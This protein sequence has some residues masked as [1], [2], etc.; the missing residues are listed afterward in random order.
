[1]KVLSHILVGLVFPVLLAQANTP[2]IDA[3]GGDS[4]ATRTLS[5]TLGF[6]PEE[7][8]QAGGVNIVVL[9]YSVPS[10]VRWNGDDLK[11]LV[12]GEGGSTPGKVRVYLNI[13]TSS[14]PQ[15]GGYFY[16]QSNG[17]DLSVP[18]SGCL[19]AFPRV[20]YWDGDGRKDLLIGKSDGTVALFLNNGTDDQPTFDSG[21]LLQVG[22]PGVKVPIDVSSRATP[23]VAD[24]NNDGKKDLIVGSSDGSIYLYINEG[25]DAAPDFRS[26]QKA[27]LDDGQL[28]SVASGRSSP[29]VQDLDGDGKKD[30]LVGNTNGQLFFYRNTAGDAAPAFAQYTSAQSNG[31][32]IDLPGA[33]RSRPFVCDWTGDGLLDVLVGYGDSGGGKVR[34]YQGVFQSGDLNCD[35]VVTVADITHFVQALI[36]PSAY[37]A[38]HDGDPYRECARILADVNA[39]MVVDGADIEL[40]VSALVSL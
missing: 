23:S 14:Y 8:V 18:G 13:G 1:M 9:G 35:G 36:D 34:L 17:A 27:Q 20:V 10:F 12:V 28:I 21:T 31:V 3:A 39:D 33:L 22:N 19:G 7:F 4:G 25:T 29:V 32:A 16:A 2:L 24:W 6:G 37:A 5:G 30:L 11:D 40:F 15:F 38:D 26:V